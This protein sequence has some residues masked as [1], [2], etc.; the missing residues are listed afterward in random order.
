MGGMMMSSTS[1]L[2]IVRG[3]DANDDADPHVH[4]IAAKRKFLE[5]F[6]AA[7]FLRKAPISSSL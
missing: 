7:A 1:D 6:N 3:G 2:T 4:D 5:F